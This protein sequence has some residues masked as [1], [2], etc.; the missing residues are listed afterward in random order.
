M[1]L[2]GHRTVTAANSACLTLLGPAIA[3][4]NFVRDALTNPAAA[5][6]IANTQR[7]TRGRG[8]LVCRAVL[9]R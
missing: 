9:T 5:Q 4:G 8:A 6:T 1:I 7:F 3:G 2:D